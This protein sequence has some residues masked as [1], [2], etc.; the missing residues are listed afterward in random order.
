MEKKLKGSL[1][2]GNFFF[3]FGLFLLPS[4]FSIA[5]FALLVSIFFSFRN[6]NFDKKNEKINNIFY[7]A[8]IFLSLSSTINFLENI[9]TSGLTEQSFFIFIDLLNWIPLILLFQGSQKYLYSNTDRRNC[10]I[11]LILG[12][13]PVIFSCF[14]QALLNWEGPFKTFFGL[15]VWYQRPIDG[16]TGI[17][18]LFSNPNYLGTWLNIIWPFSLAFLYFDNKKIIKVIPKIFLAISISSLIVLTASRGAWICLLITIPF[19]FGS[20]IKKWLFPSLTGLS[21]LILNL[22]FPIFGIEFQNILRTIIP[23]GIWINFT[24]AEF[25]TLDI[26]RI[27][28]WKTSL[29]FIIDK[30]FFGHGSNS[31][32][33]LFQAETGFWKGHSHNLPIELF[34]NYGIP[35]TLLILI[36]VSYLIYKSYKII[37]LSVQ[38]IT[39][40]TIIDRAWIISFY[41]LVLIHLIDIPYFDGRVSI[42]GWILLAGT[43]N[44]ILINN[45]P[46]NQKINFSK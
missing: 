12:S 23:K 32:P 25:A 28:I 16:I 11:A 45:D 43:R 27:G 13:I 36:P 2:I 7:I 3:I 18:G 15:I 5:I 40:E 44:I 31:F 24:S 19:L 29:N 1:R 34:I 17:T 9:Q 38:N 37:F 33:N 4:A 46:K 26:S 30:P 14:S 20:Q 35:T 41:L 39:K 22:S 42:T 6:N 8:C 10:I 21:L